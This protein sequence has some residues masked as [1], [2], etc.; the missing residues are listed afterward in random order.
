LIMC[1]RGMEENPRRRC[2][3]T[4]RH[5]KSAQSRSRELCEYLVEMEGAH[6]DEVKDKAFVGLTEVESRGL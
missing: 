3:E 6:G 1:A 2:S 5:E 4:A